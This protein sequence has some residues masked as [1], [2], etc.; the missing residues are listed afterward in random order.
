MKLL[1]GVVTGLLISLIEVASE[2]QSIVL[3]LAQCV[4]IA[5]RLSLWELR[6]HRNLS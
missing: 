4:I 3:D 6:T 2:R 1:T 5:S